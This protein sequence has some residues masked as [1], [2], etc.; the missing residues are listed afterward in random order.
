[1]TEK[2][3]PR[4]KKMRVSLHGK[5]AFFQLQNRSGQPEK[6]RMV[7]FGRSTVL[8]GKLFES[9]NGNP[10]N[11]VTCW[12]GVVFMKSNV[13]GVKEIKIVKAGTLFRMRLGQ[14]V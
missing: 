12:K 5:F 9:G 3:R 8:F 7:L 6:G 10:Y 1:M 14:N 2:K 11:E 4:L 13:A